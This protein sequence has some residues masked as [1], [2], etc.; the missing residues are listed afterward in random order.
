MLGEYWTKE[1]I[2]ILKRMHSEGE[3][4]NAI[5]R[6]LGLTRGAVGGKV[7]RLRD[8]GEIS[9]TKSEK[10]QRV[11]AATP[12]IKRMKSHIH[13][14]LAPESFEPSK[15][16]KPI[17]GS[18]QWPMWDSNN[19]PGCHF[20]GAPRKNNKSPYCNE[21]HA[22]AYIKPTRRS[23]IN[24]THNPYNPWKMTRRM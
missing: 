19:V 4:Y 12:K 22:I 20:C 1:K 9:S 16:S 10:G 21:H 11:R 24:P 17:S 15:P 23:P 5:G 3:S 14:E 2:N 13:A 18:C 6:V 7:G 8:A